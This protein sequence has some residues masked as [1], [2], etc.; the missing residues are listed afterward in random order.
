MISAA[1]M[2]HFTGNTTL[3]R[4][5]FWI[6]KSINSCRRPHICAIWSLIRCELGLSSALTEG[7]VHA[8]HCFLHH[9]TQIDGMMTTLTRRGLFD[10]SIKWTFFTLPATLRILRN[11]IISIEVQILNTIELYYNIPASMPGCSS[12]WKGEAILSGS[13]TIYSLST[14]W[15]INPLLPGNVG[16]VIYKFPWLHSCRQRNGAC[17][18]G[19]NIDWVA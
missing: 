12:H 11:F 13:A 4:K 19:S 2:K 7:N 1:T 8:G 17:A 10:H 18:V 16:C 3:T 9:L 6:F 14:F 15:W 5:R